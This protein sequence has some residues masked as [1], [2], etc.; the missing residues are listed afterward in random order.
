MKTKKQI[1]KTRI[2]ETIKMLTNLGRHQEASKL[3]LKNF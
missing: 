2:L 3:Y 1:E